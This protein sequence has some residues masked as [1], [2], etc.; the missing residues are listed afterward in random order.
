MSEEN[1]GTSFENRCNI[2]SEL[3]IEYRHEEDF[4][5]FVSYNDLGLQIGRAHV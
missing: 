4:K 3:W 2:L 1:K 5:D